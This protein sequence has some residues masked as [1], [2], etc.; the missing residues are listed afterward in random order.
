MDFFFY[1]LFLFLLSA[2]ILA[3][4]ER[5]AMKKVQIKATLEADHEKFIF[6]GEGQFDLNTH[7]LQYQDKEA[8]LTYFLKDNI[9]LRETSDAI[10]SYKFSINHSSHFEIY[11]KELKKT[12]H[13]QM[14]TE[15]IEINTHKIEIIYQLEG[16]DF[17]HHYTLEWRVI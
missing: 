15:K 13:M 14:K 1:I 9:L 2:I 12:A 6:A 10:L 4:K 7:K 8:I 3:V 17:S 16:N 5:H 11:V